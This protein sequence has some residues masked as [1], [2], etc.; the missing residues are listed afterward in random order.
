MRSPSRTSRALV[1]ALLLFT[2]SGCYTWQPVKLVEN[3]DVRRRPEQI[4]IR[5]KSGVRLAVADPEVRNDSLF[6]VTVA[7]RDLTTGKSTQLKPAGIALADI[8]DAR[9]GQFSAGRTL[10]VIVLTPIATLAAALLFWKLTS[11]RPV[12]TPEF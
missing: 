2:A 5:L 6:G 8:K 3:P 12:S 10:G 9:A 11:S 7:E 1:S 4:E